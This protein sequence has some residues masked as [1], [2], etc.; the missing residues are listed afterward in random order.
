MTEKWNEEL[1]E[2]EAQVAEMSTEEEEMSEE[3][4][5]ERNEQQE[6]EEQED[7]SQQQNKV[8]GEDNDNDNDTY[9]KSG[10]DANSPDDYSEEEEEDVQNSDLD[11]FL[12]S[13]DSEAEG[14]I[15]VDNRGLDTSISSRNSGGYKRSNHPFSYPD[16]Q[17]TATE[18]TILSPILN[19]T[20]RYVPITRQF[21]YAKSCS[22]KDVPSDDP[23]SKASSRS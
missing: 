8:I 2:H 4:Q 22:S 9:D 12:Y 13:S 18:E 3:D 16:T 20:N 6:Q 17:F 14:E 23:K 10:P 19:K 11:S 7:N 5:E 15:I 21:V 1:S